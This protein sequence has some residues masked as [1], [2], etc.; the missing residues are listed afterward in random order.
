LTA[1]KSNVGPLRAFFVTVALYNPTRRS[2]I[3]HS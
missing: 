2:H 1:L 3:N